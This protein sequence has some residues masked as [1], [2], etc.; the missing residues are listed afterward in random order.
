MKQQSKILITIIISI[1]IVLSVVQVTVSNSLSTTGITLS[2]IE[3]ETSLYKQ[4]NALLREKYLLYGSFTQ[5][6]SKAAALGFIEGRSQVVVGNI[7][8]IAAA[9]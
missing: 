1:V 7:V 3:Q 5:I 9:P 2:K 8:P 6:A 4:E